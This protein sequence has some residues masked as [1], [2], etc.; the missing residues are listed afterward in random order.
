MS[1]ALSLCKNSI[2]CRACK[3]RMGFMLLLFLCVES[4]HC[5]DTYGEAALSEIM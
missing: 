3:A 1:D 4:T 2:A 5:G